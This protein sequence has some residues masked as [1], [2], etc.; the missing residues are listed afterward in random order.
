[1][2]KKKFY[3]FSVKYEAKRLRIDEGCIEQMFLYGYKENMPDAEIEKA[4]KS[5]KPEDMN[6]WRRP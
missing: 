1:M 4:I 2:S 5:Y 6:D 3:K